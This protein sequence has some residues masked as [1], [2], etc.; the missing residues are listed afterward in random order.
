MYWCWETWEDI[1]C[2]NLFFPGFYKYRKN[3]GLSWLKTESRKYKRD[4]PSP[5]SCPIFIFFYK[6][7][8]DHDRYR[9]TGGSGRHFF[10]PFTHRTSEGVP[11]FQVTCG[12]TSI[13]ARPWSWVNSAPGS[14]LLSRDRQRWSPAAVLWRWLSSSEVAIECKLPVNT[15]HE[16]TVRRDAH[17]DD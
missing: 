17:E 11:D 5:A 12:V 1:W 4:I 16:P 6:Y 8:N 14:F 7:G 9:N 10:R 13:S 3:T 2:V 15:E